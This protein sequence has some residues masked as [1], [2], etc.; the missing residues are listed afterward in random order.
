MALLFESIGALA[1]G[2]FMDSFHFDAQEVSL[3]MTLVGARVSIRLIVYHLPGGGAASAKVSETSQ[4]EMLRDSIDNNLPTN[5][6]AALFHG[7]TRERGNVRS[8]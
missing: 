2:V 3:I 5:E 1:S 8:Q 4:Q 7:R 6:R